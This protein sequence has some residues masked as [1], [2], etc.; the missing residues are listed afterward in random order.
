MQMRSKI[1]FSVICF[2]FGL[3][4][5]AFAE[6]CLKGDSIH[7]LHDKDSLYID[8]L[9]AYNKPLESGETVEIVPALIAGNNIYVLNKVIL[10]GSKR[11]KVYKRK[12]ELMSE[13]E[14]TAFKNAVYYDDGFRKNKTLCIPYQVVIPYESWMSDA[15]F[16]LY[17]SNCSCG[18]HIL[19][20]ENRKSSNGNLSEVVYNFRNYQISIK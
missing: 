15:L 12:L 1:Y 11:Q 19:K 2:L 10:N 8:C 20:K 13:K 4:M 3:Q 18:E 17:E 9:L 7:V 5:T 14:R 16:R 6:V